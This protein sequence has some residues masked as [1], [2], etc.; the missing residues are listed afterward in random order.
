MAAVFAD[1]ARVVQAIT[2]YQDKISLAVINGPESM[3]ISGAGP[4]VEMVLKRFEAESIGFAP[5]TVSHAFHSPLMEPARAEL[6][7]AIMQY[8]TNNSANP[9]PFMWTKTADQILESIKRFC[10]RT[11]NSGH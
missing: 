2:P 7:K 3:V 1:E 10:L 4:E 5:L 11:S 9:K 6:E 8:V